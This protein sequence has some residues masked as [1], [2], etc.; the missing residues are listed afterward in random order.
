MTEID[1]AP[2]QSKLNKDK[3]PQ[4]LFSALEYLHVEVWLKILSGQFFKFASA[5]K[6]VFELLHSKAKLNSVIKLALVPELVDL[7]PVLNS[8]VKWSAHYA[9]SHLKIV[10]RKGDPKPELNMASQTKMSPD[11]WHPASE[12]IKRCTCLESLSL[13]N[14]SIGQHSKYVFNDIVPTMQQLIKLDMRNCDLGMAD[15]QRVFAILHGCTRLE[16][17]CLNTNRIMNEASKAMFSSLS[18]CT[19]LKRLK[20]S[21]CNIGFGQK[22][23][24]ATSHLGSVVNALTGLQDVDISCNHVENHK[25]SAF[26]SQITQKHV[27]LTSLNMRQNRIRIEGASHLKNFFSL[28]PDLKFLDLGFN[29]LQTEA[30]D[31]LVQGL[32]KLGKL[33]S[34]NL[35][36]NP[37]K[38]D[39]IE[40]LGMGLPML[41]CLHALNLGSTQMH[42][43]G[44]QSL[45]N[46]LLNMPSLTSLELSANTIVQAGG[47][48]LAALI[49]KSQIKTINLNLNYLRDKP[50]EA[51][52]KALQNR[53]DAGLHLIMG[54][55]NS[56]PPFSVKLQE[57]IRKDHTVN[58]YNDH[59]AFDIR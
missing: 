36:Q 35:Y 47:M 23:S 39:G 30:V 22:G 10:M 43:Q 37:L 2:C 29:M 11:E 18:R 24:V 57:M 21:G 31:Y 48:A 27:H 55:K 41:T 51:L 54:L 42:D 3:S 6:E 26:F 59:L 1:E 53:E 12:L 33:E 25:A 32:Q 49:E 50:A 15:M 45:V 40:I 44:A 7:E 56:H 58:V 14:N 38:C 16:D 46:N 28:T 52:V 34:L 17:L 20:L 8:Q 9:I 4:V 5:S 19:T 13:G